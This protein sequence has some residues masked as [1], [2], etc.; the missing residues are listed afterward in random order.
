M[1]NEQEKR[2]ESVLEV[3]KRNYATVHDQLVITQ[4]TIRAYRGTEE[5]LKEEVNCY[6]R[7][8]DIINTAL[9]KEEDE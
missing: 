5:A 2:L 9:G 7:T 1:N 6:A 3:A 4:N 8:I